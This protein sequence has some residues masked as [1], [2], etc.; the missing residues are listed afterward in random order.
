[1]LAIML[2]SFGVSHE[3]EQHADDLSQTL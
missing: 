1:V 2:L 3:G